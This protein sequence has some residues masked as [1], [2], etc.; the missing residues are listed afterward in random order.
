VWA[1]TPKAYWLPRAL[2]AFSL[3]LLA[4]AF[5]DFVTPGLSRTYSTMGPRG[6]AIIGSE[7][8]VK[9]IEPLTVEALGTIWHARAIAEAIP[10][11]GA[12]VRI[13][14]RDGLT[15]VV[16]EPSDREQGKPGAQLPNRLERTRHG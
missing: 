2:I 13:T 15:L 10:A 5:F 4:S 7:A 3:A 8:L 9:S 12:A 1:L 16:A 14:D 6:D 11:V